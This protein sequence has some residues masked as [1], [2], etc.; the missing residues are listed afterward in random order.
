[1]VRGTGYS[2]KKRDIGGI[3]G[4]NGIKGASSLVLKTIYDYICVNQVPRIL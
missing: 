4:E 2:K 3:E 1:M